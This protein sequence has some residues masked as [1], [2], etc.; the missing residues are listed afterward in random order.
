M[1]SYDPGNWVDNVRVL[2]LKNIDFS[3]ISHRVRISSI[4]D[5]TPIHSYNSS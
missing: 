3:F 4:K 2:N 1:N 5:S